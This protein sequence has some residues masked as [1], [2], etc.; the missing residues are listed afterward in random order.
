MGRRRQ[1]S[2]GFRKGWYAVAQS[3][4]DGAG[5]AGLGEPA[6][7]SGTEGPESGSSIPLGASSPWRGTNRPRSV[8]ATQAGRAPPCSGAQA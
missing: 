3:H 6:C 4:S 7:F 2:V 1:P 8:W 5:Y